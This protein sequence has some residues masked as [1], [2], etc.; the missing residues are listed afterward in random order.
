MSLFQRA[1]TWCQHTWLLSLKPW[2][3]SRVRNGHDQD[4]QAWAKIASLSWLCEGGHWTSELTVIHGQGCVPTTQ[5]ALEC[6]TISTTRGVLAMWLS[7]PLRHS[8]HFI[9]IPKTGMYNNFKKYQCR[10][11]ADGSLWP[12]CWLDRKNDLSFALSL[13]PQTYRSFHDLSNFSLEM[14]IRTF[15]F[16]FIF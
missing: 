5:L 10:I 6:N 3:S 13:T 4:D 16:K 2:G 14:L 8:Y 9:T 11:P 12:M 15:L 1:Y 7:D